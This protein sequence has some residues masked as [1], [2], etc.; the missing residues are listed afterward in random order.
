MVFKMV[1]GSVAISGSSIKRTHPYTVQEFT[2]SAS[3]EHTGVDEHMCRN[4]IKYGAMSNNAMSTKEKK[5][6]SDHPV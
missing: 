6:L 3:G 1:N 4:D 2:P 5:E